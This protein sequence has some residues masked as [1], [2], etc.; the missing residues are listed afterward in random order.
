M[1][2]QPVSI[3]YNLHQDFYEMHEGNMIYSSGFK[4]GGEEGRDV[5]AMRTY[6]SQSW[7]NN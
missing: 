2:N 5:R 1:Q 3:S 7:G 6:P 4:V